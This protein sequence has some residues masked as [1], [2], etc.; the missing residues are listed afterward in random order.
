[1]LKMAFGLVH[2]ALLSSV[3]GASTPTTTRAPKHYVLSFDVPDEQRWTQVVLDH[4]EIVKEFHTI[5]KYV[6]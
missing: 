4:K 5:F 2:F 6:I 3:F 1:M